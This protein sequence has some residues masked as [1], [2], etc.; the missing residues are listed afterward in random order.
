[1]RLICYREGRLLDRG[2]LSKGTLFKKLLTSTDPA[3]VEAYYLS[4]EG[5]WG[6]QVGALRGCLFDLWT[7]GWALICGRAFVTV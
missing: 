4:R 5:G 2:L 6:I 1:M 7:W 3:V